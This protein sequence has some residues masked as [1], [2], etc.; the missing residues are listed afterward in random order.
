MRLQGCAG[1]LVTDKQQNNR[2]KCLANIIRPSTSKPLIFAKP[3]SSQDLKTPFEL[4]TPPRKDICQNQPRVVLVLPRVK[5]GST[6]MSL[7]FTEN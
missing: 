6:I 3:G 1:I 5:S 7:Y 2:K 4:S